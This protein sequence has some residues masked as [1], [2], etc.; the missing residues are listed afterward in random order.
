LTKMIE[1]DRADTGNVFVQTQLS[2]DEKWTPSTRALTVTLLSCREGKE[3]INIQ[4]VIQH[5]TGI[6]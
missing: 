6:R 4:P 1:A 2:S 3:S 5:S